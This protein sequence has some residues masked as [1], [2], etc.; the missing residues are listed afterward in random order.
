MI[1]L[2]LLRHGQTSCN[3]RA[4]VIGGRSSEIPLTALGMEQAAAAGNVIRGCGLRFDRI[5]C[6]TAVRARQ[7]LD[8]LGVCLDAGRMPLR[9]LPA[10]RNFPKAI[11]RGGR[12]L[13]YI[14]PRWSAAWNMK[15]LF[16]ARLTG[17]ASMMWRCA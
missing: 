16:S 17:R 7:T 9:I 2:Y 1:R 3:A 6:S 8:G 10:W 15:I 12:G 13:K 5:F 4:D 14:R 11:G